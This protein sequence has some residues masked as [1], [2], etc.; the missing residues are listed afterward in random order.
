MVTQLCLSRALPRDA[1][2]TPDRIEPSLRKNELVPETFNTRT[3]T[4]RSHCTYVHIPFRATVRLRPTMTLHPALARSPNPNFCVS[5]PVQS[6]RLTASWIFFSKVCLPCPTIMAAEVEFS[7]TIYSPSTP[8]P[9]NTGI[10]CLP[11]Y[12]AC[13]SI[14]HLPFVP[15]GMDY[16]K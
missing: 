16:R 3:C 15:L 14:I 13:C 12:T 4:T 8:T 5:Q 11:W 7:A 6:L 2:Q 9:P 10:A 1:P